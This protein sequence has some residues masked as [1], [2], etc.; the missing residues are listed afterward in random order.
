M[1]EHVRPKDSRKRLW[2]LL[3]LAVLTL[4]A[5]LY[6][7]EYKFSRPVGEGPAGATIPDE[8]FQSE[9]TDRHVYVLGI[10]DSITAGLGADSQSHRY[11]NRV[12]FNPPDEFEEMKGLCLSAVLPNLAHE[13]LAVSGSESQLHYDVVKDQVVE[14]STE[15]FGIVLMTS[16]GNDLIHMYGRSPPRECAMYG[17]TIEQAEPWIDRYANR[18]REMFSLLISRFPGGCEIYIGDI[19][20]PT[21]GQGDAPSIFL[22]DWPDG[23]AIHARYNESIRSIADE[24][25]N[26]HVV[27][28]HSTFMGHGSHCRQWWLDSYCETDPHYWFYTN[29]EDPNDRGYDAIRRAFLLTIVDNTSLRNRD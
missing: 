5:V 29:V 11:F 25:E 19:Y 7:R 22:P 13:N 23:L 28:L 26:V 12:L 3:S 20:D 8:P 27:P 17:A 16:G 9:W 14:Q 24:F 4:L 2:V 1:S 6:V 10:G 21:D 15:S 18:L